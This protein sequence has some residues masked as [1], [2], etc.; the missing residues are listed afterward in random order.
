M[1]LSTQMETL[2]DANAAAYSRFCAGHS[3]YRESSRLLVESAELRPGMVVVDLGCG[4]GATT[5][6]IVEKLENKGAILAVDISLNMLA[7]AKSQIQSPCVRFIRAPAE[8]LDRHI[9][10]PVDRVLSNF[11]FFQFGDKERVLAALGR[12]L[13]PGGLFVFNSAAGGFASL[14]GAESDFV[15][16][17]ILSEKEAAG[18]GSAANMEAAVERK[19]LYLDNYGL[20]LLDLVTRDLMISVREVLAFY[21]I[22]C[23]GAFLLGLPEGELERLLSVV[24]G[25]LK[26]RENESILCRHAVA[27]IERS[28]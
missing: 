7:F 4:T 5:A 24:E 18:L 28:A 3:L 21:R 27:V 11:A 6:V 9:A 17:V 15:L 23:V 20:R 19:E 10:R 25:R 1:H 16:D 22:P 13:K 8:D 26:G 2:W 12:V 14:D